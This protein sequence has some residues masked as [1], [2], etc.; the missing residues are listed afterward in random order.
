[1][2]PLSAS[3]PPPGPRSLHP[4]TVAALRSAIAERWR[5]ASSAESALADIVARVAR[6]ARESGLQ[7][8]SLIIALKG[9]EQDV[10]GASGSLRGEDVEARRRFREW[11]VSS[12]VRAY[13]AE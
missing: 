13:F 7:P 10:L 6:E 9:I 11:L 12:C 4:D 3:P 1:M 5:A 8:E 2:V